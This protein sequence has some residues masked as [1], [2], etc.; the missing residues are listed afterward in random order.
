MA[1]KKELTQAFFKRAD[2][3]ADRRLA[4]IE[5][6]A[7]MGKTAC[8]GDRIKYSEFIPVIIN[9]VIVAREFALRHALLPDC[10]QHGTHAYRLA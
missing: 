2:L 10:R 9:Y 1:V 8:F 3:S 4:E 5:A 7:S 6:L